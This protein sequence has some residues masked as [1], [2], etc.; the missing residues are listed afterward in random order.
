MCRYLIEAIIDAGGDDNRVIYFIW[1]YFKHS[2][3]TF[4]SQLWIFDSG[5]NTIGII[6]MWQSHVQVENEH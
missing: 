1:P 2:Y 5:Q 3:A 6:I 4:K